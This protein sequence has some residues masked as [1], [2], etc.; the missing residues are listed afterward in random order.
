MSTNAELAAPA[1]AA[2]NLPPQVGVPPPPPI[3][4]NNQ[5]FQ[6][7]A[8]W[9]PNPDNNQNFQ[10]PA[11]WVPIPGNNQ[12]FQP[13]APWVPNPGNNQNF[14]PPAP[15][16]PNP[17]NNQNFQ[18]PAPVLPVYN[19][20]FTTP[21]EAIAFAQAN[22]Q[23]PLTVAPDGSTTNRFGERMV[24]DSSGN[25]APA[26]MAPMPPMYVPPVN[27]PMPNPA[28]GSPVNPGSFNDPAQAVAYAI[29]NG[30]GPLNTRTGRC[31]RDSQRARAVKSGCRWSDHQQQWPK[32]GL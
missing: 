5:N 31:L 23:G 22:G 19:S 11:P 7:P 10:P 12:N 21:A 3:H 20:R 26:P 1:A 13:P 8:P 32:D 9:V 28:P 24:F 16:V 25:L 6:P 30:Q 2:A 27:N 14:Q 18:P 15:V 4:G 17:G 29:A